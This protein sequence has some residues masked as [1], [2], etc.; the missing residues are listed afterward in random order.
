MDMV[1]MKLFTSSTCPY[2]PKAEKVVSK[3]AKEEG[4]LAIELPVNTDEGM[5][6]ALKYGIRGVPAVVI[7]EAYLI[8]GVPD[9]NE[10]R[11][12]VRK[13]KGGDVGE[14]A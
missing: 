10:L 8:L 3:I 6:E 11:G 14:A 7:N 5:K 1:L 4:V 13:L 9:E 12:L 2:C